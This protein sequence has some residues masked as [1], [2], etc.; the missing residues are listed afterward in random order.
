MVIIYLFRSTGQHSVSIVYSINHL[1]LQT[2]LLK[3]QPNLHTFVLFFPSNLPGAP[4][5]STEGS[6]L[7]TVKEAF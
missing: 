2:K 5:N 3:T 6:V 7:A 4:Y 1:I